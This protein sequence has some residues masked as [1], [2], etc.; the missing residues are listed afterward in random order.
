M[1]LNDPLNDNNIGSNW[2]VS[3]SSYSNNNLGTPGAQNDSCGEDEYICGDGVM[4][5]GEECDDG[6]LDDGD[7][8]SSLCVI[9]EGE[10]VC[11]DGVMEGDEECDD[12]NTENGDGCS[13]ICET[14][15]SSSISVGDVIINELMWMGSSVSS[16]DE[17]I[18]LRNMTSLEINFSDTP[19]S[20]YKNDSPMLVINTGILEADD[21]FLISNNGEDHM[22]T[23]GES[24]L[25]VAPDFIDSAISLPS[26]AVQYKLYDTE[27]SNN[28]PIDVADD[29]AG[30]PL[31]GDNG[32]KKSMSR[33][34]N[35][36]DG[37]SASS[38]FTALTK[39]GWDDND[40]AVERGTPGSANSM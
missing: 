40:N 19:W 7:G 38:W 26:S 10:T 15:N 18:E 33:I 8:C 28:N 20:I 34:N 9:E 16:S 17:W 14:E 22:F 29:G 35:T 6:N 21:Y 1:I 31:A 37:T 36:V 12:G 39:T 13:A 2:C 4:E 5:G 32:D 3:T 23:G 11:G 27:S 24:V 30:A 25:N